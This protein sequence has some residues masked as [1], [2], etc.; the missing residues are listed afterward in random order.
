M[1]RNEILG[2]IEI[3]SLQDLFSPDFRRAV[4]DRSLFRGQS[5]FTWKVRPGI[6][7]DDIF[8]GKTIEVRENHEQNMIHQFYSRAEQFLAEKNI[9]PLRLLML[10]QHYGMPTR[11]LD[12]TIDPLIALYFAVQSLDE[13]NDGAL[14]CGHANGGLSPTNQNFAVPP[15]TLEDRDIFKR[16]NP[17]TFDRRVSA[18]KSVFTIQQFRERDVIFTPL[19]DFSFWDT[20]NYVFKVRI[21]AAYKFSIF[22]ELRGIGLTHD[23]VFPDLSAVGEAIRREMLTKW[24]TYSGR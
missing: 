22:C 19:E 7:R 20:Y 1:N 18:Q 6:F 10:A 8:H 17:P 3:R 21:P 14:V 2:R 5:D 13:E 24:T 23:V 15:F 16:I 4:G 12:W 9:S 11:L